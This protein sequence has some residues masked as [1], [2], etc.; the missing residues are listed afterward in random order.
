MTGRGGGITDESFARKKEVVARA[1]ALHRP[2]REDP[3]DVLS[4]VGG[5]DL[6]AMCGA[7]LGAAAERRR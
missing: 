6:A 2:R 1:L 4:K 3:V 5:L 7:F